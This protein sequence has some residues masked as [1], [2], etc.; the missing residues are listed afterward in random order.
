M[1]MAPGMITVGALGPLIGLSV[2]D[3]IIVTVVATIVG[4]CLPAFTATLSPLTGLRQVV[5]SRYAFG[6]HGAKLC[7][8]LNIIINIGY[9]IIG[10]ILAGQL[11]RAVSGG[12]L[13]IAV[14]IVIIV[15]LAFLISFLG[16][17]VLQR[18]ESVAWFLI[19]ILL[20]VQWA[21]SAT[22]FPTDITTHA[23]QGRDYTG[24]GLTYFA[25]IFGQC[26]AWCSITGDYCVHFPSSISKWTVFGLTWAGLTIPTLFVGLLSCYL[27][28][29]IISNPTLAELYGTGGIGAIIIGTMHPVGFSKF[30]GVFYAL[31]CRKCLV[32]FAKLHSLTMR[33]SL[34][35]GCHLVLQRTFCTIIWTSLSRCSQIYMGVAAHSHFSGTGAWRS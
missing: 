22:Y 27:G 10:S 4:S 13:D 25:I 6:M 12:S 35:P 15:L 8:L 29:A 9:G 21:Q 32:C 7:S 16:F 30:V 28:G 26:C 31:A 11:L 24:A 1:L 23:L 14:G 2:Q 5:V 3:S 20:I 18:Y 33:N 19:A 17:N 34:K